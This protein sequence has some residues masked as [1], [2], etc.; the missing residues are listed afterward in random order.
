M[1]GFE[2]K[3]HLEFLSLV[4]L[5]AVP[6]HDELPKVQQEYVSIVKA[7]PRHLHLHRVPHS[8]PLP[9]HVN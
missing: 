2:D 3:T 7:V 6:L 1:L 9:Q 4:A 8:R 5:R